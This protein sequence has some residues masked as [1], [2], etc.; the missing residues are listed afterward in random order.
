[1][2]ALC[3]H[4]ASPV[5]Q[6]AAPAQRKAAAVH[7][8]AF[9]CAAI[10]RLFALYAAP[11]LPQ[12]ERVHTPTGLR[13]FYRVYT[14]TKGFIPR[15]EGFIPR[16]EGFIPRPEGFIPRPEGF[17]P[18]PPEGFTPRPEPETRNFRARN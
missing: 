10:C 1:M 16:L 8:N 15:P 14:P 6:S 13:F 17:I 9:F 4:Y 12:P 2:Q 3:K 7:Q 18:R 11:V 5:Q